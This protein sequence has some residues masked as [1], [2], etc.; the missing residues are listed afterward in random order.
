MLL[1]LFMVAIQRKGADMQRGTWA[2][3]E[4]RRS[5]LIDQQ[6]QK[7]TNLPWL[8]EEALNQLLT[9]GRMGEWEK[10]ES[11]LRTLEQALTIL[12]GQA[13]SAIH[14]KTHKD[15]LIL[16]NSLANTHECLQHCNYLPPSS[17]KIVKKVCQPCRLAQFC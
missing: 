13:T 5:T 7:N 12:C 14:F 11:P 15:T 8:T 10:D 2:Q 6:L 1:R 3:E 17:Q 4:A 9:E 16:V